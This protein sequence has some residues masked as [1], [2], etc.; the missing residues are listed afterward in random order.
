MFKKMFI[1]VLLIMFV[2]TSI[3]F[4]WES[5]RNFGISDDVAIVVTWQNRHGN[6]KSCGPIQKLSLS[7]RSEE[8]AIRYVSNDI[9][10]FVGFIGQCKIYSCG[11]DLKSYDYDARRCIR[12]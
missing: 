8:E 5:T 3:S 10:Y 12:N 2:F 6:W 7:E 11:R 4:A 9:L 1:A